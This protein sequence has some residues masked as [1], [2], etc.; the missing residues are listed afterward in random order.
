[1]KQLGDLAQETGLFVSGVAPLTKADGLDHRFKSVALLSPDADAFWP[2]FEQSK[3]LEDGRPDPIDR[4]SR[5]VIQVLANA[6]DGLAVLPFEGPP[7]HPFSTWAQRAGVA[8]QSPSGL[9]VHA[10]HGLWISFRGAVA[11]GERRDAPPEINKSPC[12]SCSAPCL[13]ACPVE[14]FSATSYAYGSCLTH[15]RSSDGAHCMELGCMARHACPVGQH[16]APPL[17]QLHLHMRAFA[18]ASGR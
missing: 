5:R 6:V 9:L 1:M 18:R 15:V 8:W 16:L 10:V 2:I 13:K 7:Y 17:Q 12:M 14:A 3:E 4:W 11:L